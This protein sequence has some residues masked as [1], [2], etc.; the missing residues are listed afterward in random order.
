M[1]HEARGHNY[2]F[3]DKNPAQWHA[4]H[5]LSHAASFIDYMIERIYNQRGINIIPEARIR[6]IEYAEKFYFPDGLSTAEHVETI[7]KPCVYLDDYAN[8][9]DGLKWCIDA[10]NRFTAKN[11][12]FFV[13]PMQW[14]DIKNL[15]GLTGTHK[16]FK[17]S[18]KNEKDR[19]IH[20][21]N[22]KDLRL[23]HEQIRNVVE[24]PDAETY[25]RADEFIENHI[26]KYIWVFRR[27]TATLIKKY[28][29]VD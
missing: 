8:R 23:L 24:C 18:K 11:K 12:G 25:R 15:N 5:R 1:M 3:T 19:A 29:N 14:I 16:W 4:Y 9:L 10:A 27:T 6:A 7:Y 17:E 20:T 28:E 2:R 13:L 26:P 21:K 22:I